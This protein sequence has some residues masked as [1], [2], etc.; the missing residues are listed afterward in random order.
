MLG[1]TGTIDRY[2]LAFKYHIF[3]IIKKRMGKNNGKLKI[4]YKCIK[5]NTSNMAAYAAH[6]TNQP[7]THLLAAQ[8]NKS[9]TKEPTIREME[10]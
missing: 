6:T 2:G 8:Q 7:S 3:K 5:A 9:H 1:D 10:V 4:L